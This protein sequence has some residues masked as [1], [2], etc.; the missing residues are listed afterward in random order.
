[1]N[2]AIFI[3]LFYMNTVWPF[4]Y[5]AD[6]LYDIKILHICFPCLAPAIS[7]RLPKHTYLT[8]IQQNVNPKCTQFGLLVEKVYCTNP[9]SH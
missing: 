8:K 9:D 1:M 3:Q 7:F 4:S 6:V 2:V 5:T